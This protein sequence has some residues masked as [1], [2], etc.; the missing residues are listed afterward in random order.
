MKEREGFLST[1]GSQYVVTFFLQEQLVRDENLRLIINHEDSIARRSHCHTLTCHGRYCPFRSDCV[2][3]RLM[4]FAF[5]IAVFGA[6][7]KTDLAMVDLQI[8]LPLGTQ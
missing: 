4:I 1:R 3:L 2:P 8:M 5:C 7:F 6:S